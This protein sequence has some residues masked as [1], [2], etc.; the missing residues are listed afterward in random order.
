MAKEGK[1]VRN[2]RRRWFTLDDDYKMRYYGGESLE[3]FKGYIDL[4]E[5]FQTR[6]VVHTTDIMMNTKN[7]RWVIRVLDEV[8]R[9]FL[10]H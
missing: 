2:W 10:A 3:D 5:V 1:K 8:E 6:R 9:K 7:R 4:K